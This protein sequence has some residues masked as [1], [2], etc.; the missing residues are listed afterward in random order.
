MVIPN[1]ITVTHLNKYI[2]CKGI[3]F[4]GLWFYRFLVAFVGVV[5]RCIKACIRVIKTLHC[6]VNAQK[7][8]EYVVI[9]LGLILQTLY[10]SSRY[11]FY[12]FLVPSSQLHI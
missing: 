8:K 11:T 1:D 2:R 10:N 6:I 4:I 5:P 7:C 3:L 9:S 12:K